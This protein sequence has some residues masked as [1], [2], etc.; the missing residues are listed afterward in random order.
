MDAKIFAL[1][2]FAFAALIATVGCGSQLPHQYGSGTGYPPGAYGAPYSAVPYG[3]A[4]NPNAVPVVVHG[5]SPVPRPVVAGPGGNVAVI[6]S[7]IAGCEAPFRLDLVHE[8]D[9]HLAL[10]IDGNPLPINGAGTLPYLPP[11]TR[12]YVCVAQ[13]GEHLVQGIAYAN[14]LGQFIEVS[15]FTKTVRVQSHACGTSYSVYRL[16]EKDIQSMR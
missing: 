8:T 1:V 6:G 11:R 7:P 3:N 9:K 2:V 14:R 13:P 10:M 5:P 15:R 4:G 12:L 16:R